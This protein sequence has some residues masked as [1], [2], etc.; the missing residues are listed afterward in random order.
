[1]YKAHYNVGMKKDDTPLVHCLYLLISIQGQAGAVCARQKT[2][3][4]STP[5]NIVSL[6]NKPIDSHVCRAHKRGN[7]K[8]CEHRDVLLL[9]IVRV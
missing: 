7:W 2:G 3:K 4:H 1:M 9:Y 6:N 8:I 5:V